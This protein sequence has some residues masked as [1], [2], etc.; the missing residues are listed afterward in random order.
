MIDEFGS[1]SCKQFLGH[2]F[3]FY[4]LKGKTTWEVD[5]KKVFQYCWHTCPPYRKYKSVVVTF[6]EKFLHHFLFFSSVMISCFHRSRGFVAQKCLVKFIEIKQCYFFVSCFRS[7]HVGFSKCMAKAWFAW[8]CEDEEGFHVWVY[9]IKWDKSTVLLFSCSIGTLFSW[10]EL[11]KIHIE[12]RWNWIFS[13]N[14]SVFIKSCLL[15]FCL[16]ASLV[17]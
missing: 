1:F 3:S 11:Q 12:F 2:S 17:Q 15:I 16:W 5:I 10:T 13:L 6:R 8:V 4:K 9:C 7:V 14:H